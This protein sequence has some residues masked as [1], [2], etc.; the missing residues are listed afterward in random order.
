MAGVVIEKGRLPSEGA[1][2]IRDGGGQSHWNQVA[3]QDICGQLPLCHFRPE[4][5]D[6][7]GT[8]QCPGLAIRKPEDVEEEEEEELEEDDDSLAG[9]SQDDTASPTPEPQGAYEDDEDEEPPTSLAVGFDH[10]RRWAPALCG[11]QVLGPRAGRWAS[12]EGVTSLPHRPPCQR[13]S[14]LPSRCFH[15]KDFCAQVRVR[16]GPKL[17]HTCTHTCTHIHTMHMYIHVHMWT[18]ARVHTGTCVR[19][20]ICEHHMCNCVHTLARVG[21]CVYMYTHTHCGHMCTYMCEHHMCNCM[22][23]L[24]HVGTCVYMYTHEG[25]CLY[26]S[27]Y[28]CACAHM[29]HPVQNQSKAGEG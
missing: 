27:V 26:T 29:L 17:T 3:P 28:T 12:T 1:G 16:P 25:A 13:G 15:C 21:T 23:T 20:Y 24:A 8:S 4:V 5:Q 19:A 18:R 11:P 2:G 6:L 14:L 22:H 10:T 7:D 9:K